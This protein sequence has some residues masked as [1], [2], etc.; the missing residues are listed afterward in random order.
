MTP[1]SA[2]QRP[3]WRLIVTGVPKP[4]GAVRC[5]A[6]GPNRRGGSQQLAWILNADGKRWRKQLTAAVETLAKD[7]GHPL[8]GPIGVGLLHVIERGTTVTRP[9]PHVGGTGDVDKHARMSLDALTDGKAILDDTQVVALLAF[10]AYATRDRPAGLHLFL[11]APGPG[12][13]HR[14][15]DAILTAA[16][17]L[18]QEC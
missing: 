4:K 13:Y 7:M 5:V 1:P 18:E 16:P 14:T 12:R 10:K 3:V 2:P 17:E 15:L 6:H 8:E 11:T 9:L